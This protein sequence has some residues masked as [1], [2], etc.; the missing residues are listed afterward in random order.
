MQRVHALQPI[1]R[2]VLAALFLRRQG[3]NNRDVRYDPWRQGIWK[4]DASLVED[5]ALL[6]PALLW[7]KELLQEDRWAVISRC[8]GYSHCALYEF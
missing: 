6:R 8:R 2:L 7:P 4:L 1:N 5:N 3:H